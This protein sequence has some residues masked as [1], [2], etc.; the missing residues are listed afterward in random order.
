MCFLSRSR[1]GLRDVWVPY[2]P[3]HAMPFGTP[4][5]VVMKMGCVHKP[6]QKRPPPSFV[7][8]FPPPHPLFHHICTHFKAYCTAHRLALPDLAG[9]APPLVRKEGGGSGFLAC[10]GILAFQIGGRGAFRGT[11][12]L[13]HS[14]HLSPPY[15]HTNGGPPLPNGSSEWGGSMGP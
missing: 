7:L 8:R 5:R 13:P 2:P 10:G 14:N 12:H 6:H 9:R 1:C 15:R 4:P 11:P 3:P